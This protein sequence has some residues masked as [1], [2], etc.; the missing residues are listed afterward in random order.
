M[1]GTTEAIS[2]FAYFGTIQAIRL[3]KIT[4]DVAHEIGQSVHL[5][6]DPEQQERIVVGYILSPGELLYRLACGAEVSNHYE[7]EI[8]R[9]KDVLRLVGASI[10]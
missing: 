6:T 7:F 10:N 5:K 1:P 2:E 8:I 4:I 9:E 3:M